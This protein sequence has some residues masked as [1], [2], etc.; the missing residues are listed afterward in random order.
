MLALGALAHAETTNPESAEVYSIIMPMGGVAVQPDGKIVVSDGCILHA[1]NTASGEF[2]MTGGAFRFN[3]DGS[4]DR[5]FHCDLVPANLANT[6]H[7]HITAAPDGRLLLTG[8]FNAVDG[9]PRNG[10]AMLLPDGKLDES[11]E[12][13]RG[14]TNPPGRSNPGFALYSV[15]LLTNDCVAVPFNPTT[16]YLL[17][18]TGA[19]L[20]RLGMDTI[21]NAPPFGRMGVLKSTGFGPQRGVDWS[22]TN[23]TT[24]PGWPQEHQSPGL[25]FPLWGDLPSAA[26]AAPELAALFEEMP[27]E[28][29]RYAVRLPDGGAILAV[30][31]TNDRHLM[32]FN[33]AWLPD[34][35]FT[36]SFE[37]LKRKGISIIG[38]TTN[39]VETDDA[40]YLTL[41]LQRDGKLLL[42]GVSKLNGEPVSGIGRLLPD[43]STDPSF[44]CVLGGDLSR[45]SVMGTAGISVM[46]MALQADGRILI[47][48]LFSEVN[49]VKC[50]YF[51][52]LNPDGSLDS[53]FQKHFT[54]ND[55]LLALRRVPVQKLAAANPTV[56]PATTTTN[57][58][59]TMITSEP[60]TVLITSLNLAGG[61]AVIRFQGNPSQTYILQ[62]REALDASAWSSIETN[63]TDAAGIGFLRD[64]GAKNSP[65]RFYRVATP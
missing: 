51:A 32:R 9:K 5:T 35:S 46:G 50:P 40:S 41:A 63:Q 25:M 38:D 11:F 23:R 56:N 34:F 8:V 4:L 21:S 44:H 58:A 47:V 16:T 60:Q 24:W 30:Q 17:D 62:C 49:G 37:A 10:L 61:V 20:P 42:A 54:T 29:C 33:S 27:I 28:L 12:P 15:A 3:P 57:T 36:N 45:I 14:W 48:G 13:W 52:R 6:S 64:E 22:R 39:S 31:G 55:K 53:D 2:S 43:G 1:P 18:S 59:T 26:D 7:E 65:T 19:S